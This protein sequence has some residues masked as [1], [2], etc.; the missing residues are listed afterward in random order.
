MFFTLYDSFYVAFFSDYT[1]GIPKRMKRETP[2]Y[3]GSCAKFDC[4]S[5][6]WLLILMID[7]GTE[8]RTGKV[9]VLAVH[10]GN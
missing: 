7:G 4:R 1:T 9:N 5:C 6:E 8:R 10:I 3:F 2:Q